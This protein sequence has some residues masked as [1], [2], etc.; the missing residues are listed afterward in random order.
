[1]DP[2]LLGTRIPT[3]LG[4]GNNM[5]QYL[6]GL[7]GMTSALMNI[8]DAYWATTTT[9]TTTTTSSVTATN[10]NSSVAKHKNL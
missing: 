2:I 3:S 5:P 10:S 7:L 1:M 8:A 9:T 6:I 4:G